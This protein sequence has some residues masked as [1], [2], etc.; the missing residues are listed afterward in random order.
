LKLLF[1]LVLT[2]ALFGCDEEP[3]SSRAF[4][5]DEAL[6]PYYEDFLLEAKKRSRPVDPSKIHFASLVED[7]TFLGKCSY[8][9]G[10]FVSQK[11]TR[12]DPCALRVAVFHE[13]GHCLLDLRHNDE[14][15]VTHIMQKRFEP[16]CAIYLYSWDDLVD[17][18][19][20]PRR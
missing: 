19:F 2:S 20:A 7:S 11:K 18:L 13:L 12:M 3:S 16:S 8:G 14:S 17:E 10:I 9:E 15:G 1:S 5:V 6:K 4:H